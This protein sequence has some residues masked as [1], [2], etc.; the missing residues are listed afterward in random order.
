MIRNEDGFPVAA[1][2]GWL[3]GPLDPSMAEAMSCRESLK[4]LKASGFKNVVLDMDALNVFNAM[5]RTNRDFSYFGSIIDD[6]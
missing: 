4:W 6:C 2:N 1:K 3:H 5:V